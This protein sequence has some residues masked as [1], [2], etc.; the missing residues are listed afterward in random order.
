MIF[1]LTSLNPTINFQIQRLIWKSYKWTKRRGY[2]S[3]VIMDNWYPRVW[4][5][6]TLVT[7]P[8]AIIWM[9]I[10]GCLFIVCDSHASSCWLHLQISQILQVDIGNFCAVKL[11]YG[12]LVSKRYSFIFVPCNPVSCCPSTQRFPD[13]PST[14]RFPDIHLFSLSPL[15]FSSGLVWYWKWLRFNG[16]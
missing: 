11:S 14:Q 3:L 7:L 2:R 10:V 12:S 5:K 15:W 9:K 13:I 1:S 4:N 16:I 6:R 8:T